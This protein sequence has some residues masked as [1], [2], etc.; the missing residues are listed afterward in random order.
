MTTQNTQILRLGVA[1][2]CALIT[3]LGL[4]LPGFLDS[5]EGVLNGA[6]FFGTWDPTMMIMMPAIWGIGIPLFWWAQKRGKPVLDTVCHNPKK[7]SLDKNLFFGAAIFGVGWGISGFCPGQALSALAK[8][9]VELYVMFGGMIVGIYAR[10]AVE[11]IQS[12]AEVPTGQAAANPA[13]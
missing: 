10:Y 12:R 13:A 9:N 8:P 2:V 4:A 7:S 5:S 11:R 1:Y 3:M 6:D